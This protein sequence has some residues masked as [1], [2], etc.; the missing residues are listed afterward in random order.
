MA[1]TNVLIECTGGGKS[2]YYTFGYS[3]SYSVEV[4][5]NEKIL[6]VFETS[7]QHDSPPH[8][9]AAWWYLDAN[10]VVQ[11]GSIGTQPYGNITVSGNKVTFSSSWT[12]FTDNRIIITVV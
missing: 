12:N 7:V 11:K 9:M 2:Y 8:Q 4:G 3:G 6:S 10:G 1:C 5:A